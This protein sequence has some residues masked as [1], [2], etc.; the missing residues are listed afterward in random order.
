MKRVNALAALLLCVF[1]AH[2]MQRMVHY[3]SPEA[4]YDIVPGQTPRSLARQ[5]AYLIL[6][7]TTPSQVTNYIR[8]E[9]PGANH[10]EVSQ[11]LMIAAQNT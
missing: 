9:R 8:Q 1:D 6:A 7:T 3:L 5:C 4:V 2:Q 10:P 11:W